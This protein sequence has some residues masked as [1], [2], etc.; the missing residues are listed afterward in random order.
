MQNIALCFPR[1]RAILGIPSLLSKQPINSTGKSNNFIENL[2]K[3]FK[4]A[5][6]EQN[7]EIVIHNTKPLKNI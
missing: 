6:I 4:N 2:K 7:N 3:A 5:K 1:F